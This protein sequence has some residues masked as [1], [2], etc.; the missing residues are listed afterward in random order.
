MK[1]L[2][3]LFFVCA[4]ATAHAQ[5][6]TRPLAP[7]QQVIVSPHIRVI[8]KKG[9]TERITMQYSGIDENKINIKV[10]GKLL[11]V[12]LENAKIVERDDN[13]WRERYDESEDYRF[14]GVTAII[15]YR[16]LESLEVRGQEK[17]H[18]QHTLTGK[19][20]RLV[21]YG[22][23]RITIDSLYVTNFRARLYGTNNLKIAA[24]QVVNQ[25]YRLYGDNHVEAPDALSQEVN[26]VVYGNGL[27]H[28]HTDT[29]MVVSAFGD[30][31]IRC[32]GNA[33]VNR[34]LIV[35]DPSIYRK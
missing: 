35:G 12:Y 20:F 2:T 16:E 32:E 34:G 1:K 14:A 3:L 17:I 15:T 29:Q 9:D 10:S 5:E 23:S 7:F 33:I 6:F 27:L 18:L 26:T 28:V 13:F 22:A 4:A 30:P 11:R 31:E 21:A 8:L 25:K 24:G 19:D